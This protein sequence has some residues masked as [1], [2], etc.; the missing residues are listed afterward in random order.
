MFVFSEISTDQKAKGCAYS[1]NPDFFS[2]KRLPIDA[3]LRG[4][5]CKLWY[6]NGC[7]RVGQNYE[8]V[9]RD[10][11]WIDPTPQ[12]KRELQA[13]RGLFFSFFS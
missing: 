12:I 4:C 2:V 3:I 6:P 10:L 9:D 8:K 13:A 5:F 7:A 1:V 11:G